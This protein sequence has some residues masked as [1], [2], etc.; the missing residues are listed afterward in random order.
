MVFE[1][2]LI[3]FYISGFIYFLMGI[4]FLIGLSRKAETSG[5]KREFVSVIIAARDEEINIRNCLEHLVNHTYPAELYEV[6]V[7]DDNSS[8]ST[9]GIVEEFSRN[10]KN[11]FIYKLT[12]YNP[13]Y[14]PKKQALNL[15]IDRS[16]G[17][18]ILTM[19]AD[20]EAGP[21]WI[22]SMTGG[23]DDSTGLVAGFSQV[24]KEESGKL[25]NIIQRFD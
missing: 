1:I 17:S 6:I 10:Y 23:F 20:C 8:D 22:E 19:D 21:G 7:I 25:L 18:M 3:L 12:E 14:S 5:H 13:G 16:R 4:L 24:R 15:G 11:I 9:Y 2:F